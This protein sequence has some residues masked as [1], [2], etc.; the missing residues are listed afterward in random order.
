MQLREEED[1]GVSCKSRD[2]Q[3]SLCQQDY[4]NHA[5]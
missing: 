2:G 1:G 3:Y 5:E 4:E